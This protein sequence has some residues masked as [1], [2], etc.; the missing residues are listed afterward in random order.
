MRPLEDVEVLV[1]VEGAIGW[2][3][4]EKVQHKVAGRMNGRRRKRNEEISPVWLRMEER[5]EL[6]LESE[7]QMVWIICQGVH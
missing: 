2:R 4:A 6:L 7:V 5:K 3:D 1:N